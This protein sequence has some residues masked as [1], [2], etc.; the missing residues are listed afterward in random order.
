MRS[1]WSRVQFHTRD[2][3]IAFKRKRFSRLSGWSP[4]LSAEP[5]CLKKKKNSTNLPM[6]TNTRRK[7]WTSYLT[8][9]VDHALLLPAGNELFLPHP[10]S[11]I[12]PASL[13]GSYSLNMNEFVSHLQ[14]S[15]RRCFTS[16]RER[17]KKK[18]PPPPESSRDFL[19]SRTF[20][21]S[22]DDIIRPGRK[23]GWLCL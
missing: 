16:E 2:I 12:V 6:L 15:S 9:L 8:Y 7:T 10:S 4:A 17:K 11:W 23:S 19:I 21:V 13:T 5:F 1:T 14:I 20:P 18:T 22:R 3:R